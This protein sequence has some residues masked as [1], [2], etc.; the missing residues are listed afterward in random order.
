M[1]KFGKF[2]LTFS[3]LVPGQNSLPLTLYFQ[4]P[5]QGRVAIRSIPS[6]RNKKNVG[7]RHVPNIIFNL[8]QVCQ[9]QRQLWV[10]YKSMSWVVAKSCISYNRI[11]VW[12]THMTQKRE[13]KTCVWGS[14]LSQSNTVF[15]PGESQGQ[16]SLV[17]YS[18]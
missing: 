8:P 3:L 18:P 17:N 11:G 6:K 7:P 4:F 1:T 14:W 2:F 15:L 16:R 13:R 5:S 10:W 12:I 9:D